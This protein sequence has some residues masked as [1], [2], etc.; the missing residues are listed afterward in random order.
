MTVG[1]AGI[2]DLYLDG[3]QVVVGWVANTGATPVGRIQVG[4]TAKKT[5]TVNFDD[6]V[7]DGFPG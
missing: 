7:V 6:V 2:W 5:F 4:D 1:T 3:T